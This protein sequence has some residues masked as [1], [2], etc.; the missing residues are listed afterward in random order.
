MVI[1]F[2]SICIW[3][4]H[5]N[6]QFAAENMVTFRVLKL[7]KLNTWATRALRDVWHVRKTDLEAQET[8]RNVAE[9]RWNRDIVLWL[10]WLLGCL[11]WCLQLS[12]LRL[13]FLWHFSSGGSVSGVA[14]SKLEPRESQ[15]ATAWQVWCQ[16]GC[17]LAHKHKHIADSPSAQPFTSMT[18]VQT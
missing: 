17:G 1:Y 6:A 2:F 11:S 7:Y 9:C 3:L 8:R 14:A 10:F 4:F 15:L 18:N 5:E 12:G 13:F 16:A